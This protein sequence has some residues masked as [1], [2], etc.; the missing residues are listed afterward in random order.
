V[1]S[2][3]TVPGD[4][5]RLIAREVEE[6]GGVDVFVPNAGISKMG[7]MSNLDDDGGSAMVDVNVPGLLPGVAAALPVFRGQG[8]GHFVTIVSTSRLKIVLNQE[9]YAATRNAVRTVMDGLRQESTDGV[10]RTT[11]I[12]PG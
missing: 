11:L 12:S 1:P 3:V 5:A 7:P 2:D 10:V 8:H 9:A 6:F 4:V